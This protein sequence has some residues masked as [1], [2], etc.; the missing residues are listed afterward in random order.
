MPASPYATRNALASMKQGCTGTDR[1]AI[2]DDMLLWTPAEARRYFES[3]GREKPSLDEV[4]RRSPDD[5]APP[6]L[7]TG[8]ARGEQELICCIF[9]PMCDTIIL[10]ALEKRAAKKA[11]RAAAASNGPASL[12]MQR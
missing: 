9:C 4:G 3:A 1:L 6:V 2:S 5:I 7:R 10:D 8:A 12:E 11:R